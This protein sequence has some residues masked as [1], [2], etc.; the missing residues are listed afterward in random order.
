[1]YQ[2]AA[3]SWASKKQPTVA[4][5]TTES[6]YMAL[7][8]AAQESLWL[9]R[10]AEE[11]DPSYGNAPM[12]LLCDS[13]SAI[14]LS[15]NSCYRARSKH[16]ETRHHFIREKIENGLLQVQHLKTDEITADILTKA[17][18]K[19]KHLYCLNK[20]GLKMAQF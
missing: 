9:K 16:I 6:E 4:L 18:P 12:I 11:L 1:M 15:K 14:E 5:S 2:G 7:T 19:Q 3:I 17:L 10:L 20:M 13:R 8:L